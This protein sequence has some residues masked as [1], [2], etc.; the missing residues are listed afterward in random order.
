M[1]FHQDTPDHVLKREEEAFAEL[2]AEARLMTE[3]GLSGEDIRDPKVWAFL[4]RAMKV[5]ET[6]DELK[7]YIREN[8]RAGK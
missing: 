5:T 6:G 2:V 4:E 8:W 1:R 7:A 3:L